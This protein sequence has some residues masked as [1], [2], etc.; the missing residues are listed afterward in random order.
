MF[1]VFLLFGAG[2]SQKTS[3]TKL[4]KPG[5][6]LGFE[7]MVFVFSDFSCFLPRNPWVRVAWVLEPAPG[8][9]LPETP[10]SQKTLRA[11][12]ASFLKKRKAFQRRK[13]RGRVP[14]PGVPHTHVT[15]ARPRAAMASSL[16]TLNGGT[17]QIKEK[18][19]R[20]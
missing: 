3:K 16:V 13:T 6:I 17:N 2:K 12:H 15:R 20:K 19:C 8:K 18:Y 14:G 4:K 5:E 9:F 10:K 7:Q 11:A 1:G